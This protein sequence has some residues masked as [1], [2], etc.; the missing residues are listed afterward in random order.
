MAELG[1]LGALLQQAEDGLGEEKA[2]EITVDMLDF[3]YVSKCTDRKKLKGI[4]ERLQSGTDGLYPEVSYTLIHVAILPLFASEYLTLS[5]SHLTSSR[6]MIYS[7]SREPRQN[8]WSCFLK[9]R[10]RR[11]FA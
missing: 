4:L 6:H 10:S 11:S 3:D 9:K 7:L 5:R 1:N 8:F 2:V